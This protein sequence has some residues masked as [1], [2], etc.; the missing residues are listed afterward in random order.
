MSDIGGLFPIALWG[1]TVLH[2]LHHSSIFERASS[3]VRNQWA[4]RHSLRSLPLK[5]S[6]N[7]LSVGL[8]PLGGASLACRAMGPGEVQLDATL[9]SP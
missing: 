2:S 8:P 7:A 9:I 1:R 4:F 6:I 5:D 3:R